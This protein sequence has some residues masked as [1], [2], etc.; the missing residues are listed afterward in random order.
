MP[1]DD[2][3]DS[4]DF[5]DSNLLKRFP[6][7]RR[8]VL[9]RPGRRIPV[10]RQL[11]VS[12]CG[13]A[14][15]A[16]V[17]GYYG[18]EASLEDL[19]REFGLG[20]GRSGLSARSILQMARAHGLRGR[21][22]RVGLEDLQF[23]PRG[24]I[25]YW[26]FRHFVVFDR[27]KNNKVQIVD[28]AA[29]RRSIPIDTFRRTFTGVALILEPTGQ[30]RTGGTKPK[31]SRSLVKQ[32][33]ECRD[34]LIKIISSSLLV[35]IFSLALPLFTGVLIDQVVPRKDYSLLFV[36]A[37]GFCVF[38]LL[39]TIAGFVR[40]HLLIHLRTQLETRFT[41]RFLDHLVELPYSYFQQHSSG[42]LM[43]RL[44]SNNALRDILATATLSA[45]MDG[46]MAFLYLGLLLITSPPMTAMVALLAA[47]R[48]LLLWL[49][50]WRQREF[51]AR[52]M[53]NQ[54]LSSTSQVELLTGMETL[55]AM[56]LEHRAAENWSNVFVEGLNISIERGRLDA[57][58]STLSNVVGILSTL[59]LLFYGA[60][61]VLN[62]TLSLG[63]MLAFNALA[64]SFLTPLNN[65]ISSGLQFQMLEV[66][67]DRLNDVIDAA[68]E[69]DNGKV[70]ICGPL[71]GRISIESLS[72]RYSSQ[73]PLSVRNV[74]VDIAPGS[75]VALVG[76]TG[77]GKSTLARLIAGLYEPASGKIAFDSRDLKTLDRRSLRSQ[78]GFVAQDTQLF[79]GSI[80]HNIALA[81]PQMP[82]AQVVHAATI[83]GLHH[84]I[85][86]MPMTYETP[87][88]DRG[89]SLSGGQRQRLA[90]AR[91]LASNPR[92]L[93]LDEATSQ[94]DAITEEK[95]I[96]NLDALRCTQVVIAHRLSTVRNADLILV[97]ENGEVVAQGTHE[98]LL[99]R[100][101][102]YA[103][104]LAAQR[105]PA[106]A[107]SNE[108]TGRSLRAA[109]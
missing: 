27:L 90:I 8:L 84:D 9:K 79:S 47:A 83:A 66:Y 89:L 56:G 28:P 75:R 55:K 42:D 37:L 13:A 54:A 31:R 21:G 63:T 61:L 46:T 59:A 80:R 103:D 34:L 57:L 69:Q 24:A 30:F 2:F 85:M 107:P 16:M 64:A 5:D 67:L 93:I 102:C 48:L 12:D 100:A 87:L 65:V 44:G 109:L 15:L 3:L 10:V 92:I 14:A 40:S 43:V 32:I 29:G 25:L 39:N 86:A 96:A 97:L 76:R 38:Q 72:F 17:L 58:F 22:V 4:N 52:S 20:T 51:L 68:P 77:S 81:N 101:G 91:A 74:T 35:Q 45:F 50:R 73:D 41:L 49:V 60:F 106:P 71:N 7:L 94:L 95:V 78:L 36:L 88:L 105:D 104:L 6:G 53:E 99:A 108:P 33:L 18:R 70:T 11:A 23:L 26:A 19:R 98:E 1:G 82:L 62:G